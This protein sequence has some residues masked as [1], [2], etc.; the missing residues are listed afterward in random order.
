MSVGELCHVCEAASARH[1]CESCG[2]PACP[3][4]FDRAAGVCALCGRDRSGG[5]ASGGSGD[6]PGADDV[7]PGPT[8]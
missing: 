1:T 8:R 6:L 2:R 5:D 4:H 3:D 7:G